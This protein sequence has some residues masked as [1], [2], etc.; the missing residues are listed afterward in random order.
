MDIEAVIDNLEKR[1]SALEL[2]VD[3]RAEI[4]ASISNSEESVVSHLDAVYETLLQC[5][6]SK[7]LID[8]INLNIVKLNACY[9]L[10]I[11]ENMAM[12]QKVVDTFWPEVCSCAD[13]LEKVKE[14][15][16]KSDSILD[17]SFSSLQ[18]LISEKDNV[19]SLMASNQ[20]QTRNINETR[21]KIKYVIQGF[22]SITNKV[23]MHLQTIEENV[24]ALPKIAK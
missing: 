9:K 10:D 5:L 1:I 21:D 4:N 13:Q 12:K 11:C 20:V 24:I 14:V 23:L 8:K 6:G 3:D 16:L 7:S 18:K 2:C 19:N 15:L 17:R 22:I